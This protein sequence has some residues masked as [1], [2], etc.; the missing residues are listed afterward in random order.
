MIVHENNLRIL[1]VL[2]YSRE[3]FVPATQKAQIESLIEQL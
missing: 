2:I 3:I 1:S